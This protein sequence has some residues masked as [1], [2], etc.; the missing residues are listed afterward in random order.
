MAILIFDDVEVLDFAGPFEVFGVTRTASGAPAYEVFVVSLDGD[1]ICARNGLCITPHAGVD[2]LVADVLVVPG[3]Y[4]ARVLLS[5][6]RVAA[7]LRDAQGFVE[8][9]LSVCTGALLLSAAGLLRD[10]A[11][12]THSDALDELRALDA[13]VEIFPRAR[14]VDNGRIVTSAGISA[15]IDASLYLVARLSGAAVAAETARYMHYDWRHRCV[16]GE[17]IVKPGRDSD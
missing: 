5:D 6:A 9:T 14:V 12:T 11:A 16:D 4:G 13:S 7:F 17:A 10:L 8:V 15:G 1:P 3:G 2:A